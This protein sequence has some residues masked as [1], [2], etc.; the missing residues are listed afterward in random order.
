MGI[1]IKAAPNMAHVPV[2]FYHTTFLFTSFKTWDAITMK[3]RTLKEGYGMS[4][5][6]FF[7][8]SVFGQTA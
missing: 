8:G 5:Q 6:F 1:V 4:L 3:L 2:G 7:L